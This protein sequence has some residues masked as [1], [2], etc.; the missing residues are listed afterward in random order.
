MHKAQQT[1]FNSLYQQHLNAL[2]RQGKAQR[3]IDGYSRAVRRITE[4]EADDSG[5]C[6]LAG[7]LRE[8]FDFGRGPGLTG[9]AG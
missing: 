7:E 1:R 9:I 2:T 6:I 3:T 8:L 5:G 4:L